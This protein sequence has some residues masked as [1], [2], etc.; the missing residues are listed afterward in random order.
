MLDRNKF[1]HIASLFIS[2]AILW[3]LLS[4]HYTPLLLSLGLLSIIL[5]TLIALR[6]NLIAFEQPETFI[7]FIKYIPYGF[8]LLIEI[9][10]SN[11]DVCKRILNPN[12]PI[13]PRWITIKSSQFS[14]FGKIIYAN[15][16]TL[17]P[18]TISMDVD[19][20]RI[21]VHALSEVGVEGLATGD[22][23]KRISE[24]EQKYV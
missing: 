23:D 6:M 4:G 7:Q 9:L 3:L 2:L 13:S 15:S 16:I 10:K 22:M 20:N 12:L 1:Y 8:W 11:I 24:V 19:E 18:G 21:E 17:T 5:V 14:E